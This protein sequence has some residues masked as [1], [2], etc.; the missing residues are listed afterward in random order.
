MSPC[1]ERTRSHSESEV[2]GTQPVPQGVQ[3]PPDVFY[4]TS[5]VFKI[6]LF[7]LVADILKPEEFVSETQI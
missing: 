3:W 6:I 2:E 5:T 1:T 4:F 7:K